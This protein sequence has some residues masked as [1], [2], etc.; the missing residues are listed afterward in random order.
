MVGSEQLGTEAGM[1]WGS[2]K[3]GE[4]FTGGKRWRVDLKDDRLTL[5][6]DGEPDVAV[7]LFQVGSIEVSPGMIW[8]TCHFNLHKG[9]HQ[10]QWKS[11][12]FPTIVPSRCKG[13]WPTPRPIA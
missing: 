11:M 3:P 4:L 6:V 10:S 2:S 7:H 1:K 9:E 8:A 12:A 5:R 13:W